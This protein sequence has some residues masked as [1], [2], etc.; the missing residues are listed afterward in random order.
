METLISNDL[1]KAEFFLKRGDLVAVPT[2]TVYGLAACYNNK[3]AIQNIFKVKNRPAYDPLILHASDLTMI[4]SLIVKEFPPMA[5]K[6]AEKFWPGPL[7]MVLPKNEKIDPVITAGL[8]TVALRIPQH[9]LLLSLISKLKMPLAAPSANPFGYISPTTAKHVNDQLGGQIEMILDGGPAQIGLESTIV[10]VKDEHLIVLRA[11]GT[12]IE[13]LKALDPDLE[14]KTSS[15]KPNAPGMLEKHYA[16]KKDF[17]FQDNFDVNGEKSEIGL[18]RFNTFSDEFPVE[19]QIVLSPEGNIDIAAQ[20]LY[21]AM[22]EMDQSH[23]KIILTESFPK[24][25]IGIAMN[26]RILRAVSRK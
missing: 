7:S 16:P 10:E 18:I 21:S 5:E 17:Q 15:S 23:Y 14:I 6:L 24:R 8:D 25:G 4:K 2:E 12:S 19:N 9:K 20:K 26:D 3:S 22:R 11:G 13:D 1:G